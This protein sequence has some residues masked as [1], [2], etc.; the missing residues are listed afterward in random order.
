MVNNVF[1]ERA[2]TAKE[3]AKLPSSEFG[4]PELRKYP[5]NDA[6]HVRSA[7]QLFGHCP[8]KYKKSLAKKIIAKAEEY[9]IKI[10]SEEI[11]K[12]KE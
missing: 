4:I 2:L 8:E 1:L 6:E 10:E 11:L 9:N 5:L 12:Y 3:K 7:I